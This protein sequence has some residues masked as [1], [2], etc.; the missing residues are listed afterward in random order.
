MHS[1]DSVF[2]IVSS[3]YFKSIPTQETVSTIINFLDC[4]AQTFQKNTLPRQWT[5]SWAMWEMRRRL[6]RT[7]LFFWIPKALSTPY[8]F[9]WFIMN[10]PTHFFNSL[11]Q[12]TNEVTLN[13]SSGWNSGMPNTKTYMKDHRWKY[14]FRFCWGKWEV[15]MFLE[16][17]PKL[18]FWLSRQSVNTCQKSWKSK[19]ARFWKYLFKL[20]WKA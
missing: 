15:T 19:E 4:C 9:S 13:F 11:R 8:I 17:T 1:T 20:F 16:P 18:S 5:Y 2:S 3:R 12:R 6:I 10:S 14:Q 7:W